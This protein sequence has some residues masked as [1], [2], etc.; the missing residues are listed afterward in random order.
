MTDSSKPNI[1]FIVLDGLRSD[2][3]YG[4]EKTSI[5]PN[6][7]SLI[8]K[9]V[10]FP[11]TISHG[12]CSVPS[13]ASLM[14]SLLPFEALVQDDNVFTINP[15]N[16]NNIQNFIDNGYTTYALHQ[17]VLNFIGLKKIFHNIETYHDSLKLWNGLGEKIINFLKSDELKQPWLYYVQIYDLHLLAFSIKTRLEQGPPQIHDSKLGKNHHDRLVSVMDEWIGKIIETVDLEKTLV[18][19]TSD[20]GSEAG[21]YTPEME[22][23]NDQ[24]IQAREYEHGNIFKLS[25][26]IALSFPSFLLPLRKKLSRAYSKRAL[27]ITTKKLEPEF[28]RVKKLD[29]RP[30]EKRTMLASAKGITGLYD[31]R[32]KI[33]LLFLGPNIPSNKIIKQQASSI[34]IFPTILDLIKLGNP[35]TQKY[36]SSLCPLI[37]GESMKESPAYLDGSQNAPKF[38]TN[39]LV[40]VRTSEYKYFKNKYHDEDRYL[41]DLKNDPLEEYNIVKKRPEI[42]KEMN[43]LLLNFQGKN[44][45]DFEKDI[46][47]FDAEEERKIEEKLRKLGY[48]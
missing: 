2:K 13:I 34:D 45:F 26:K 14:T 19:I 22:K 35:K 40:G 33:P 9:G 6:I 17:E 27:D 29:L 1:L 46:D 37:Y 5:T 41:F 25:H 47:L 3:F 15:K 48:M 39:D 31:E 32:F 23:Y 24:N 21:N 18:I 28:E 44:G 38:I 11:Q 36:S 43:E 12:S 4:P 30:I 8:K 10:Y 7:D 16:R 20:H 42:A